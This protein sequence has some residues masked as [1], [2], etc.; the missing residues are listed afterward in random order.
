MNLEII[1]QAVS[2]LAALASQLGPLAHEL[3]AAIESGDDTKVA[4]L[5]ARLQAVN[6]QLGTA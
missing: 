5:L 2:A 3:R 6:D 4:D 1:L